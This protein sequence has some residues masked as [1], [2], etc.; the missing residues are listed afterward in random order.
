MNR[1]SFVALLGAAA[2]GGIAGE[3]IP[4]GR[5]WS[6]PKKIIV[7]AYTGSQPFNGIAFAVGREF[8]NLDV[9]AGTDLAYGADG[10][11]ILRK[12]FRRD[13]TTGLI[14][15]R[16]EMLNQRVGEY[17]PLS[18]T[19]EEVK[20]AD[21]PLFNTIDWSCSERSRAIVE[22]SRAPVIIAARQA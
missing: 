4:F 7:P 15:A 17:E 14:V 20:L 11:V 1:R 19:W 3:A 21:V 13:L 10:T 9:I 22:R 12:A 8:V 5:V 2:V 18:P 16:Y 6:F